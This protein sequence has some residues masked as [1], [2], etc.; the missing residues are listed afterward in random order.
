MAANGLG[1][2]IEAKNLSAPPANLTKVRSSGS[3]FRNILV[4]GL[5][6]TPMPYFS[7]FDAP[8]LDRLMEYLNAKYHILDQSRPQPRPTSEK[9]DAGT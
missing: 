5:P 2:G 6:G 4:A 8:K 7:F 3:F 9:N 1:D